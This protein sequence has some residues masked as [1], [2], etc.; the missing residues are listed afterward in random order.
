[1]KELQVSKSGF[2]LVE[3]ILSIA[4]L[5]L[6]IA[7]FAGLFIYTDDATRNIGLRQQALFFA[8]EGL[9]VA[10]GLRG[11]SLDNIPNGVYGILL[12]S[13]SWAFNGSSDAWG[14]F[15]RQITID[16]E[17]AD[18]K[19]ITSSVSWS[20]FGG[21]TSNVSL[22]TYLSNW[23]EE[24]VQ[25]GIIFD[26]TNF[27]SQANN[28]R[29]SGIVVQNISL[30]IPVQITGITISWTGGLSSSRLQQINIDGGISEY[31]CLSPAPSCPSSD[32]LIPISYTVP[33]GGLIELT[34]ISFSDSL[35]GGSFS[36]TIHTTTGSFISQVISL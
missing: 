36:I 8:S 11:G 17:S 18:L 15:T 27:L 29:F 12:N 9:E 10:T 2:S 23:V 6:A 16:T 25:E 5:S 14:I 1:V 19:K 3:S 35:T 28:R 30:D 4:L 24:V 32:T 31:S 22:V 21:R 7:A 13:G 34:N 33:A 26:F 20:R